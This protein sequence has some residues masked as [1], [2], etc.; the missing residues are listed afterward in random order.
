MLQDDPTMV[1]LVGSKLAGN[2]F[3]NI[4]EKGEQP[5][6]AAWA[7][8]N[9]GVRWQ[10]A[11]DGCEQAQPAAHPK[12]SRVST[13]IG[14][15][16]DASKESCGSQSLIGSWISWRGSPGSLVLEEALLCAGLLFKLCG[17][18]FSYLHPGFHKLMFLVPPN[19]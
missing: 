3:C 14:C 15:V 18:V 7:V 8:P 17:L 2:A 1:S 11:C 19:R 12:A 10:L 13:G 5:L 4:I 9:S 16:H 6:S